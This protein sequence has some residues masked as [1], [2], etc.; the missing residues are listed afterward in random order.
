MNGVLLL[1]TAYGT[2]G[3]LTLAGDATGIDWVIVDTI[4]FDTNGA[5]ILSISAFVEPVGTMGLMSFSTTPDISFSVQARSVDLTN[6]RVVVDLSALGHYE[7]SLLASLFAD[8]VIDLA[9]LFGTSADAI[10]GVESL[11]YFEIAWNNDS[12]FV[13]SNGMLAEGWGFTGY[14]AAIPEPATLAIIGLGLAGL[15]WA[16]RRQMK[17][18]A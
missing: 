17:R 14:N 4:R 2:I 15:G 6:G 1:I 10:T 3:T 7:E 13:F 16:R 5:G 18:T 8:S 11:D 9:T 12:F